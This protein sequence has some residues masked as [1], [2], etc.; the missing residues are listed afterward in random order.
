MEKNGSPKPLIETD[1]NGIYFLVT[2]AIN[3]E[4]LKYISIQADDIANDI[5][6]DKADDIASDIANDKASFIEE[7]LNVANDWI[8]IE[9]LF[10]A[11]QLSKHPDNRKKYLEPILKNGWI[12]MEYPNKKTSPNQRY[13]TSSAGKNLLMTIKKNR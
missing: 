9:D 3:P 13:R 12:E 6:N 11:V 8:K 4:H 7:L 1:S 2:L 5:V 10:A